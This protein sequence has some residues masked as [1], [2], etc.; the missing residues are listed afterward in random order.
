[1]AAVFAGVIIEIHFGLRLWVSI[2]D[3]LFGSVLIT[4]ILKI[5][6]ISAHEGTFMAG[7]LT[8]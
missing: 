7:V 1:M 2:L 3:S 6:Q 5:C 8:L 4:A